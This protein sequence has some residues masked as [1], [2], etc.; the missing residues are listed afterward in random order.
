METAAN[1]FK[2]S[3]SERRAHLERELDQLNAMEIYEMQ[4]R[5]GRQRNRDPAPKAPRPA[6]PIVREVPCPEPVVPTRILP[7]PIRPSSPIRPLL[8]PEETRAVIEEEN[9]EAAR[10]QHPYAAARDG[11]QAPA[12][13]KQ[14]VVPPPKESAIRCAE[15]M[16]NLPPIYDKEIVRKVYQRYLE[17]TVPITL[18][19]MLSLAP[20]VRSQNRDDVTTKRAPANKTGEVAAML[21]AEIEDVLPFLQEVDDEAEEQV[22]VLKLTAREE[23]KAII[24]SPVEMAM[25]D[26]NASEESR[27][28]HVAKESSAL[29][30]IYPVIDNN[31]RV[32]CVVDP[33]SQIIAMSEAI[34]HQL[35]LSYDPTIILNMQLANGEVDQS[36]GDI[37]VYCQVHVI[38]NPA[39]KILLGRPFD[40]LT[41]SIV[42]NYDT[43][44]QTLTIKDPNTGK[45]S[46]IPTSARGAKRNAVKEEGF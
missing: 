25:R 31:M 45:I 13:G 17:A 38:R 40:V 29:R 6:R 39:Y 22:A 32:E 5:A 21:Q 46:T 8:S 37:T 30:A 35:S 43:E 27:T 14:P 44:E 16:K 2:L 11:V 36:L 4:T 9:R 19:E 41:E 15:A 24:P 42:R 3:T 33:G 1:M 26:I 10:I 12:K 7:R 18:A 23:S 20:E 28:V 34:C